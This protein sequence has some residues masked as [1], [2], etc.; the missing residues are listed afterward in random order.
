M[1]A[2]VTNYPVSGYTI[3]WNDIV[4]KPDTFP[5]EHHHETHEAGGEDEVAGGAAGGVATTIATGTVKVDNNSAGNPVALTSAGHGVAVD[6]HTQYTLD[7]DFLDH[8]A[9]VDGAAHLTV[10]EDAALGGTSGAPSALNKFVTDSDPR[11]TNARTAAAHAASHE[12]GG[13]D[14]INVGGLSGVLADPQPPI[15]GAGAAQAVAGNDARLTNARTPTA[16]KASHEK[17]GLDEINLAGMLGVLANPQPPIIGA[18]GTEAVAGNDARLTDA[19]TPTA[20]AASHKSGGA[21]SIKLDELAAPT[22]VATLNASTTAHGLL[23][24]LD[25]VAT[26]FMNGQGNWAAPPALPVA[27]TQAQQETGTDVATFVTPGRQHFHPSACKCFGFTTGAGT[28]VLNATSYNV[29]S[30]TDT[31]IGRLTVTIGT[32]FSTANWTGQVN[33]TG[34]TAAVKMTQLVTKAAGTVI[35]ESA[36]AATTLADPGVGWDWAF[37]GD[38]A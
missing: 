7:T 25:N 23:K 27:A 16:H 3:D 24:K 1:P 26:N 21:D 8:V 9:D 17:G 6:P 31:A 12:N 10:D 22:D 2:K 38:F 28:P 18:L 30:I 5:P 32:D 33:T 4:G 19:R 35:L 15:I 13:A 29:T 34:L 11:N 36:S 14:E 37:F 20:H